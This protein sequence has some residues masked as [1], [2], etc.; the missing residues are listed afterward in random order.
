[1]TSI[2]AGPDRPDEAELGIRMRAESLARGARADDF[3]QI[4]H[5]LAQSDSPNLSRFLAKLLSAS[6]SGGVN[7]LVEHLN[8]PTVRPYAVGVLRYSEDDA[9]WEALLATAEKWGADVRARKPLR[10][11]LAYRLYGRQWHTI[12]P[13][14]SGRYG[15]YSKPKYGFSVRLPAKFVTLVEQKTAHGGWQVR[16]AGDREAARVGDPRNAT[17][18]IVQV[19]AHVVPSALSSYDGEAYVDF[20]LADPSQLGQGWDTL[21]QEGLRSEH[22]FLERPHKVLVNG[23]PAVSFRQAAFLRVFE[24]Y[25][26]V[27]KPWAYDLTTTAL[28]RDWATLQPILDKIVESFTLTPPA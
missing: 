19:G 17:T 15:I 11:R 22:E 13:D 28:M 21:I 25:L 10:T 1:M 27:H 9:V 14:P 8:D 12:P 20:A 26:L 24:R 2:G 6:G 16:F 7:V 4:G 3:A 5:L 18:P 23:Y